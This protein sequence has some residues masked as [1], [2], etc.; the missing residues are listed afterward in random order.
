ML[1]KFP[2]NCMLK[3]ISS[4]SLIFRLPLL[5]LALRDVDANG[6]IV[7]VCL[8]FK[9]EKEKIEFSIL[10]IVIVA[11]VCHSLPSVLTFHP[12]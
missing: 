4:F 8:R 5:S 1:Y 6:E 9:G 10:N 2:A 3:E 12:K 7:C 11:D